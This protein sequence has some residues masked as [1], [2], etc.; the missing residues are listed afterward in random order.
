MIV[1]DE[2]IWRGVNE[3]MDSFFT[4]YLDGEGA[5]H[6]LKDVWWWLQVILPVS[7]DKSNL[8]LGSCA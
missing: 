5:I 3:E 8:R 6:L 4:P 7:I 2:L 1:I